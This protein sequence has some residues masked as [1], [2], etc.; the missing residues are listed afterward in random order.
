M[1]TLPYR[2]RRFPAPVIPHTIW[3][4]LRFTLSDPE[5]PQSRS[6]GKLEAGGWCGLKPKLVPPLSARHSQR[7]NA[8]A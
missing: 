8:L 5:D 2:G 3:L 4:Y 1:T 6:D 7:D